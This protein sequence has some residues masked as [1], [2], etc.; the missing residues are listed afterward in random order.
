LCAKALAGEAV[1]VDDIQMYNAGKMGM[2]DVSVLHV[3]DDPTIAGEKFSLRSLTGQLAHAIG[4]G[5]RDDNPLESVKVSKSKRRQ[6]LFADIDLDSQPN[7][8]GSMQE[9]DQNLE[10]AK[11]K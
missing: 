11:E 3:Q 8:L 2:R 1:P 9:V 6:R 5:K 10:A 4:F 7:S